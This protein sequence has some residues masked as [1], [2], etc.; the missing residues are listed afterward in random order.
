[1]QIRVQVVDPDYLFIE[2]ERII[3]EILFSNTESSKSKKGVRKVYT[4]DR[5][6]GGGGGG[7]DPNTK[8]G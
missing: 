4:H 1:M 2:R 7:V 5:L 3:G 8:S 6:A